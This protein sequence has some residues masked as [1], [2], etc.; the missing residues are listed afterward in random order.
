ML[1]A[2]AACLRTTAFHCRQDGECGNGGKCESVGF[3]SFADGSCPDGRRFGGLSDQFANACV[4]QQP[5]ID[6]APPAIDAAPPVFSIGGKVT[7]LTGTGLA[8]RDNNTDALSVAAD[9][10][11][12]FATKLLQGSPYNVTVA[13]PPS[14]QD[15]Y[16]GRASGTAN[17][18]VTSVVVSCFAAGSDPGVLCNTGIYCTGT[19]E[20]C[21]DKVS[22]S[23]ECGVAGCTNVAMPCD[24]AHECNGGAGVCCAQ[25]HNGPAGLQTISCVN[26]ASQCSATGGGTAEILCD[27]RDTPSPCQ[28]GSC[29]GTSLLG[30]AYHTCK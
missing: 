22:L 13:T 1:V 18:N 8:L 29:T 26:A 14:G 9:G 19:T 16:V 28:S 10:P 7:G 5:G 11:F 24:S 21:F 30:A 6:A 23:G 17:A 15:A 12:T 2:N 4:G 25:F 20:C 3:C 27:P